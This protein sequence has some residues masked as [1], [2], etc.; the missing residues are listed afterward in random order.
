MDTQKVFDKVATH[1]LMQN[2]KAMRTEDICAYR[3][4]D[5]LKFAIGILIPDHLYLNRMDDVIMGA[6][7]AVKL[8]P[9]LVTY[10]KDEYGY[11]VR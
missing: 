6:R 1:L 3:A 4:E 9:A 10:F 5:G 8:S 11:N 7:E 2:E